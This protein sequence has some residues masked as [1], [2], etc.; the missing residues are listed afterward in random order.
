MLSAQ[1]LVVLLFNLLLQT[2][3]WGN[4]GFSGNFFRIFSQ[5]FLIFFFFW[6]SDIKLSWRSVLICSIITFGEL[7][8]TSWSSS[9][10][11]TSLQDFLWP[12]SKAVL[13]LLDAFPLLSSGG[14]YR[15]KRCTRSRTNSFE[16]SAV[17]ELHSGPPVPA[18]PSPA[19]LKPLDL[20]M[21]TIGRP[22]KR[23]LISLSS[24]N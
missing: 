9:E 6:I 20:L 5:V 7:R 12:S 11:F 14:R 18:H 3:E 22:L 4:Y 2:V 17:Q 15:P 23:T 24:L 1:F 16:P 10:T 13:L 21:W 8:N 19:S